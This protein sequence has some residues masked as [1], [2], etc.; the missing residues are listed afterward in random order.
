M[1]SP[2]GLPENIAGF[3]TDGNFLNIKKIKPEDLKKI[4]DS[5]HFGRD[6]EVDLKENFVT[7]RR[8]TM[9]KAKEKEE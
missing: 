8:E 7:Y 5:F 4:L 2:E 1:Y 3:K 6:A 9:E